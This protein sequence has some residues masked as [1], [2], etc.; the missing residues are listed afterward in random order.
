M[1][2]LEAGTQLETLM[3]QLSAKQLNAYVI[4]LPL[5]ATLISLEEALLSE[6]LLGGGG[7]QHFMFSLCVPWARATGHSCLMN[8]PLHVAPHHVTSDANQCKHNPVE[9]DATNKSQQTK[10]QD[11]MKTARHNVPSRSHGDLNSGAL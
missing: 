10:G 9:T 6:G 4:F 7:A 3:M 5:V 11:F 2:P 1:I 8:A